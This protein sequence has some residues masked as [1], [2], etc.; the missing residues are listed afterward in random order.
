MTAIYMIINSVNLLGSESSYYFQFLIF[1]KERE[2]QS[3]KAE[4]FFNKFRKI[5][6][7]NDA[8]VTESNINFI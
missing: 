2:K 1:Y 5:I 8:R 6:R 7:I 4:T 3:L